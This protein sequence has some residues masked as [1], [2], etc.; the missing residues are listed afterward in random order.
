MK[1]VAR[2]LLLRLLAI[3]MGV[4]LGL[5]A[6]AVAA[7]GSVRYDRAALDSMLAPIALYPDALLS[8]V[9]MAAT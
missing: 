5:T 8:H 9:L 6:S 2:H 4:S 1:R 7:Q 3:V